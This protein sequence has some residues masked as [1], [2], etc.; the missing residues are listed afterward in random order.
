DPALLA[1]AGALQSA[2][3]ALLSV[4]LAAFVPLFLAWCVA[5]ERSR[6]Q[7]T[8]GKR[9]L[10]LRVVAADG[11]RA[12][13]GAVVLR[14]VAGTL[15]WL[16]LNLGHLMAALPPQ[17]AALHDHLSGTRVRLADD[18]REALPAWAVA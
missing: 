8:P 14:F 9:A 2:V 13:L 1:A 4:A 17:H 7:A 11:T 3:F 6:W 5:F 18:V 10:G 15:S 16:T 12:G